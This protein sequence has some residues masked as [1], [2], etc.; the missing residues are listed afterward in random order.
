MVLFCLAKK[1]VRMVAVVIVV[2]GLFDAFAGNVV[3]SVVVVGC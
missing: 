3:V 2:V 1:V